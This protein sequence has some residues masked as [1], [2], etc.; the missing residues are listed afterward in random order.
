MVCFCVVVI[1][2]SFIRY[3]THF[4]C[5]SLSKRVIGLVGALVGTRYMDERGVGRLVPPDERGVGPCV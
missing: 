1:C 5:R 2:K 3:L 4:F